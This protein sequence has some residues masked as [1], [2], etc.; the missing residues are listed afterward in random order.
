MTILPATRSVELKAATALSRVAT[1]P[2][3]VRTRPSRTRRAISPSWVRS[4]TTTK[5]I[6]RPWA[7]RAS[8]RPATVTSVPPCGCSTCKSAGAHVCVAPNVASV[9]E[10]HL[11]GCDEARDLASVRRWAEDDTL[12]KNVTC[13]L[14]VG[15]GERA[16]ASPRGRDIAGSLA[17][18]SDGGLL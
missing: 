2:M 16:E 9:A 17:F 11:N 1:L 10:P 4:E 14:Q 7:G 13:G 18:D 3:C 8:G 12:D 6:A 15:F 5:S